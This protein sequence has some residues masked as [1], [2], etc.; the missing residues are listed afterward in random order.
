MRGP[1][2]GRIPAEEDVE[3]DSTTPN[4]ALGVVGASEHLG[5]DV[6]GGADLELHL[7]GRV[8][9]L[10]GSKVDDLESGV[11][12]TTFEE[13]VLRLEVAMDDVVGVAVEDGGQELSHND[14]GV[15]LSERLLMCET[16]KEFATRAKSEC[17]SGLTQ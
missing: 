6:V 8:K 1:V 17:E 14:S 9:D 5:R 7:L 4:V 13:H 15:V 3:D 10:G 11:G 12:L 16:V 2:E